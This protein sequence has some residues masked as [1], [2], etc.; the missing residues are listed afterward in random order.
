MKKEI[1]F[2][3]DFIL[4]F[5][6]KIDPSKILETTIIMNYNEN[7]LDYNQSTYEQTLKQ[8]HSIY[9]P[10]QE[11]DRVKILN[12]LGEN[13][14]NKIFIDLT[15]IIES[16]IFEIVNDISYIINSI[17]II[18]KREDNKVKYFIKA[19]IRKEEL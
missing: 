10:S 6:K 8:F 9:F 1:E 16:K 19:I 2:E 7:P 5:M 15:E 14:F 12:V 4:D 11:F 18:G 3:A 13:K 17:S